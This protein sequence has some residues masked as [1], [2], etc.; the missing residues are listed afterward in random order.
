MRGPSFSFLAINSPLLKCVHQ[1]CTV[2]ATDRKGFGKASC[3]VREGLGD[4]GGL[5]CGL[6]EPQADPLS[7]APR[8]RLGAPDSQTV[9]SG[10]WP[11]GCLPLN[12]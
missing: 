12:L 11:V 5:C 8:G 9:T 10:P 7:K 1:K 4:S 2:V 3:F 6:E